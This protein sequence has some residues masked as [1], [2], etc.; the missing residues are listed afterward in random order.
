MKI[1]KWKESILKG[2]RLLQFCGTLDGGKNIQAVN[3]KW[4]SGILREGR[5]STKTFPCNKSI[6]KDSAVCHTWHRVYRKPHGSVQ[7]KVNTNV[8]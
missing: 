7:H 1:R 8:N 6:L 5:G 2:Y 3:D 4:L